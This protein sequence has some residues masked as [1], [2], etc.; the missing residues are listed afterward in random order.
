MFW[1]P[2]LA[3][4]FLFFFIWTQSKVKTPNSNGCEV[5][6]FKTSLLPLSPMKIWPTTQNS[7]QDPSTNE[8]T[9]PSPDQTQVEEL[10][11]GEPSN[12]PSK[13]QPIA[14]SHLQIPQSPPPPRHHL[15]SK[16]QKQ[17]PWL[18]VNAKT[19]RT[20]LLS[21]QG[22]PPHSPPKLSGEDSGS[23]LLI[24]PTSTTPHLNQLQL[25]TVILN[26]LNPYQSLHQ[27]SERE[28]QL[29]ILIQCNVPFLRHWGGISDCLFVFS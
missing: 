27:I 22:K 21:L 14:F 13:I 16:H 3:P 26:F 18:F 9:C 5:G 25:P 29:M 15:S 2:P 24:L 11:L 1:L 19:K 12:H 7:N 20:S 6:K 28:K 17:W 4:N 10:N 8:N 23:L